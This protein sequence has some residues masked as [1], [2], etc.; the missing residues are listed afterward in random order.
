MKNQ[1]IWLVRNEASGS[2]DEDALRAVRDAFAQAGNVIAGE[3][4]FPDE[5]PPDAAALDAAGI[6]TM[7]VFGGDGTI[8]S[9]VT[10]LFGWTGRILVL[11]GGTMNMLSR[12]LH[13]DA[14]PDEIIARFGRG[15][16]ETV[17]PP[18]LYNGRSYGLT[19]ALAGPGVAWNDVREAMRHTA[20]LDMASAAIDAVVESVA[21]ER[22]ICVGHEEMRPEGYAAIAL[23]P[24][25]GGIVVSGFYAEGAADF[26]GQLGALLQRDFRKG[27]H[28]TVGVF[29]DV[30]ITSSEG[31]P[32]GLMLDGEEQEGGARENFTLTACGVDLLATD[33]GAEEPAIA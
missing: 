19:G 27:P 3:T 1:S 15:L 33:Y 24:R 31:T 18:I 28:D 17:R 23:A 4:C 8:H 16:A 12:R 26:L 11:P 5:P 32:M 25:E 6:G 30:E 10:G 20:I 7:C 9:V 14:A 29:P 13:G 22:V 21:G 2:N